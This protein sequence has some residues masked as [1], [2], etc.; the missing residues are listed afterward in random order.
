MWIGASE[1]ERIIDAAVAFARRVV[2][3]WVGTEKSASGA[4]DELRRLEA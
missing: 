1:P 4:L 2:A 3:R